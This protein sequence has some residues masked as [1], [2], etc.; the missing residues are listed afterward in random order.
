V[1]QRWAREDPLAASEPIDRHVVEKQE[2]PRYKTSPRRETFHRR[3]VDVIGD[4]AALLRHVTQ[5][6]PL[7]GYSLFPNVDAV[8][9]GTLV[10]SDAHRPMIRVSL[11]ATTRSVLQNGRFPIDTR[12]RDGSVFQKT[13][14]SD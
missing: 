14:T 2:R 5:M 12:F 1:C 6:D 3:R 9:T 10:G 13:L 7:S 11:N 4:D 8:P